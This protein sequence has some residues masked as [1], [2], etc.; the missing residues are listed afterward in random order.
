MWRSAAMKIGD[1]VRKKM[2]NGTPIGP[3]VQ[4][5]KI[6]DDRVYCDIIGEDMPNVM[7][8]RKNVFVPKTMGLIV[9]EEKLWKLY[10]GE[11]LCISHLATKAWLKV[12]DEQPELIRFHCRPKIYSH[13][14]VVSYI[15][16][17][18]QFGEHRIRIVI[19]RMLV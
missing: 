17:Y 8:L 2:H 12:I 19:D 4:V 10:K 7:I 3:Y 14:F 1:I 5:M 16:E 18:W 15:K 13:T 6:E 11:D 9:S